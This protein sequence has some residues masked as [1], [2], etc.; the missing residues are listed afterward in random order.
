MTLIELCF[1]KTLTSL[2]KPRD[3]NQLQ[4]ERAKNINCAF[5]LLDS[6]WILGEMGETY[7]GVVRRCLRQLF[8]FQDFDLDKEEVQQ[9][10]YDTVV[11]PLSDDLDNLM[12]TS[13]IR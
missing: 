7:E 2:R 5:R 3:K 9:K 12:G 4:D 11:V 13:R 10:V 1:G 8:D 6:G